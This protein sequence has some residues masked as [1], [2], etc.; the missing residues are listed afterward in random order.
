MALILLIWLLLVVVLLLFVFNVVKFSRRSKLFSKIPSAPKTFLLHNAPE[1]LKLSSDQLLEKFVSWHRE[2]G[3][4]F[5][6]TLHP[7][8]DGVIIVADTRIAEVLSLHQ[9]ERR[10]GILYKG[11]SRWI[12]TNGVFLAKGK[13]F[14]RKLKLAS[15]VFS[16]KRFERVSEATFCTL[17]DHFHL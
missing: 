17:F 7:F 10:G 5:H 8:D 4:V 9:P 2:F 11:L 14:K 16:A 6:F 1:M 12:G 3:D 15:P 13:L